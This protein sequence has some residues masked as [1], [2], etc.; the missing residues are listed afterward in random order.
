MTYRTTALII[1]V[2]F[3]A[4]IIALVRRQRL[5]VLYTY[6]WTFSAAAILA[7]GIFPQMLD[8]VGRFLGISYPPILAIVVG[9]CMLFVKVLTMDIERTRQE[10][11]IRIL[12]QR[13]A[14]YEAR[15]D[16][17]ARE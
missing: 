16:A 11:Q 7:L 5:N 15:L 17:M 14:A 10:K 1:A 6:W 2:C 8:H 9:L 13:M 12:A 4:V 3:V